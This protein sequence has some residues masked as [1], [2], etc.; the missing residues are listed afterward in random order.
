MLV[1]N[2]EFRFPLYKFFDGVAFVDTG[3]VYDRLSDF[4]PFD[5]RSSYGIGLRI[6]TPYVVLRLDYGLK[7]S[8]RPGERR[9][10]FFGS[11]G[12]AF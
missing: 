4:K 2:S 11:I 1:V 8:P 3:N 9:G 10:K 5:L 6:R 12:Q 7:F